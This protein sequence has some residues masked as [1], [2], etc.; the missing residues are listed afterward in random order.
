MCIQLLCFNLGESPKENSVV[1]QC[2]SD[3][4]HYLCDSSIPKRVCKHRNI[5]DVR[6]PS[7]EG[8]VQLAYTSVPGA[9]LELYKEYVV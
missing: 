9:N 7:R 6:V 8:D 3:V 4:K 2:Q 5:R 1:F